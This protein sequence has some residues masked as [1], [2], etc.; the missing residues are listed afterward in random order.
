MIRHNASNITFHRPFTNALHAAVG[1]GFYLGTL[2]IGAF[3]PPV[4][5]SSKNRDIICNERK[6][7]NS[8]FALEDIEEMGLEEEEE[9]YQSESIGDIQKIAF[10]FLIAGCFTL[11]SSLMFITLG[12]VMINSNLFN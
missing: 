3:L 11:M 2:L 6:V 1:V 7:E 8:S 4:A 9:S 12:G 10:P 5:L